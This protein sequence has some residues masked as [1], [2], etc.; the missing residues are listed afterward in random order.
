ML[1]KIILV[2][3]IKVDSILEEQYMKYMEDVIESVKP[4]DDEQFII[5]Y[6]I[7]VRN[8]ESRIE[9]IYP[10]FLE[11][12]EYKIKIEKILTK[13]ETKINDY[14]QNKSIPTSTE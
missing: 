7:P 3:Y 2:F 14:E 5:Q 4:S 11:N 8:E 9:C 1:E 12:E 10:I 13:L 6:F